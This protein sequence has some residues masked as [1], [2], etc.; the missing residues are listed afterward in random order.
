V[1]VGVGRIAP[2][3][4]N[5]TKW[6]YESLGA[7][8]GLLAVTFIAYAY[9]RARVVEDALDEGRFV[10]LSN[11]ALLALSAFGVGLVVA[12]IVVLLVD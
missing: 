12:T 9:R 2:D 6:P 11:R 4:G 7:G 1:S 5:V 3:V 8:Y 10:P